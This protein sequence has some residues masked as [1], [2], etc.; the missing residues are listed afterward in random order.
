MSEEIKPDVIEKTQKILGKYVSK[1][2]LS[3]KL[4]RKPP[5]R[6]LH[7]IVSA[8]VKN[9]GFLKGL[10]SESELISD[11]VKEKDLKIVFLT[12]L[13]EAV[14]HITGIDLKVKPTKVIAGLEPFETN[15]LLQAI[16]YALDKK[17]DST[18]YVKK[19]NAKSKTSD[20]SKKL[21]RTGIKEDKYKEP[22]RTKK[23]EGN[24]KN[25]NSVEKVRK[26]DNKD[27]KDSKNSKSSPISKEDIES[28]KLHKVP[29]TT[30]NR[31]DVNT[32]DPGKEK[33]L[34]ELIPD[35]KDNTTEISEDIEQSS[36]LKGN[37]SHENIDLV[38]E[39]KIVRNNTEQD[40]RKKSDRPK[41]AKLQS[42]AS[43]SIVTTKLD[44]TAE[45]KQ[46]VNDTTGRPMTSLR[47]PSVRPSSARPGAPRLRPDSTFPL[48]EVVPL[49]KINVIIEN[50]NAK[51]TD[52]E[53]TVIIQNKEL[54][55]EQIQKLL[56]IPED[57]GHL[58]EQILEQIHDDDVAEHVK[59][60]NEIDWEN[61]GFH[62]KDIVNREVSHL[63]SQIQS[64]TKVANPLGKLMNYLHEDVETMLSE[65]N[66]WMNMKRELDDE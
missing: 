35:V 16:G 2:V 42:N 14:K 59:N 21:P 4:L 30:D 7:D 8:I 6:F 3:E 15:K 36:I 27:K 41:S 37:K 25:N 50:Y 66:M 57:K 20:K 10:Y 31:E 40:T 22:L 53:E 23:G 46:N 17:I 48:H 1:P 34:N 55:P 63:R 49:G 39:E 38:V 65:L 47:P 56:D 19:V 58:V 51:E 13:I 29:S 43:K 24:K 45:S 26:A 54:E 32:E 44:N 61:E 9:T 28:K 5:F 64:L 52:E 11:N 60:K 18:E 12:K 33:S 62:N